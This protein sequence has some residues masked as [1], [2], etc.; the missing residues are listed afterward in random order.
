MSTVIGVF[1]NRDQA[2]KAVNQIRDAG[3]SNN[4]ISI[5]ARREVFNRNK[6]DD[7]EAGSFF[8]QNVTTGAATGGTLGGLAGLMVG[9]GALAIPGIGPVLAAGPIAAGLSGVAAGGLAGSL[10]DMGIPEDRGEHYEQE[11]GKGGILAVVETDDDKISDVGSFM[12]DNGARDV[13][14]H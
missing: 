3:I 7:H 13:E 9:A 1:N 10:V 4:E 11:V 2:E 14:T 12:R 5:V 6:G 8:D